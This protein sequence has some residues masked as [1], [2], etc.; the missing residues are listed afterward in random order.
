MVSESARG[1]VGAHIYEAGGTERKI[2]VRLPRGD[3]IF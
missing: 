1:L 2:L 3:A